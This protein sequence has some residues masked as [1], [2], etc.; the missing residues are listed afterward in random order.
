M[1]AK[2][3]AGVQEF[4]QATFA[5]PSKQELEELSALCSNVAEGQQSAGQ[6]TEDPYTRA[7]RYIEKHR[8]VEVF[9]VHA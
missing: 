6:S 1:A 2:D 3:C 7:V 8:I 4:P 5:V 9:Q